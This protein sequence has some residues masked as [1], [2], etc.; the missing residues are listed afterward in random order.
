MASFS[1]LANRMLW[2]SVWTD[3]LRSIKIPH[4]YFRLSI[5]PYKVST[6]SSITYVACYVCF[7][8]CTGSYEVAYFVN[9]FNKA[10]IFK[11]FK[12]SIINWR[13]RV[14]FLKNG[15]ILASL[16]FVELIPERMDWLN[17]SVGGIAW[18]L[19][20]SWIPFYCQQRFQQ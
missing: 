5:L 18:V 13:G 1:S 19:Q 6:I 9:K 8:I 10:V 17:I 12:Y 16:N 2:L 7:K 14:S 3:F 4:V 11:L 15:T 20:D